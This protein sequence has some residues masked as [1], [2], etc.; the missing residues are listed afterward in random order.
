MLKPD[1]PAP[2]NVHAFTTTRTTPD[3]YIYS[4][5]TEPVWLKQVHGTHVQDI[6]IT[7]PTVPEAD[8]SISF[9]PNTVCAIRTADCLPVLLCDTAGTQV[10][11]IHAGWR[12]LSAGILQTTCAKLTA[13]P[14]NCLAWL[15]PAIGSQS[16][17]VGRDVLNN[18]LDNGWELPVINSAFQLKPQTNDKWLANLYQLA[19]HALQQHG[20]A[21]E[22][23][24]GGEWCTYSDPERFYSYRRSKDTGRMVSLIWRN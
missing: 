8:A 3:T 5:P 7:T 16:F 22:N 21:A 10:A 18:F 24:Y 11:A 9:K 17:E 23:I 20:F 2:D 1:W 12:G 6:D 4:L 19:R 13:A 15:G 14:S